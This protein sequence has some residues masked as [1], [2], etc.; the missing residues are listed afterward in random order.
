MERP[1][2][3]AATTATNDAS[4]RLSAKDDWNK[5]WEQV[6]K[7]PLQ[8]NHRTP[9]FRDLDDLFMRHLPMGN[10]IRSLELGCCPGQYLWYFH[11]RFGHQVTGIDYLKKGCHET[12]QR[13]N[14]SGVNAEVVNADIFDFQCDAKHQPWDVVAS[15]GLVEHFTD[16][17]PC[18]QAH[19]RLTK[20]G[21]LILISIPNHAG[22]NGRLLR[23]VS[24]SLYQIHNHMT[25]NDLRKG[26]EQTGRVEILEGGHFGR[27][28]FWG[29]SI[30]RRVRSLGQIPY[31]AVRTPLWAIEHAGRMLP[32]TSFLSPNIAVVA[33][34]L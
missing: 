17:V 3:H 19:I 8:F 10:Q 18:L 5:A 22:L 4:N 12:V 14:A 1:P 25:W 23:T 20:P 26:L 13:C 24:P 6:Q 28:G 34:R 15:F 9:S 27:L 7:G 11:A 21:G 16:I 31:L 29:T 33:R 32:N 30:Y 2:T